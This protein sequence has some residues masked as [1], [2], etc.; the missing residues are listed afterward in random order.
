M[1]LSNRSGTI[2]S[3]DIT[4]YDTTNTSNVRI[5]PDT[6]YEAYVVPRYNGVEIAR[7]ATVSTT[8]SNAPLQLVGGFTKVVYDN[9]KIGDKQISNN[10]D[11]L[12]VNFSSNDYRRIT[13]DNGNSNFQEILDI[14]KA[15]STDDEIATDETSNAITVTKNVS[16]GDFGDTL[17]N[18]NLIINKNGASL[19]AN[20]VKKVTINDTDVDNNPISKV[21]LGNVNVGSDG[22]T[23]GANV[24]EIEV[25]VGT[26]V[27]FYVET[28]NNSNDN[29]SDNSSAEKTVK[30]NGVFITA[31][32]GTEVTATATNELTIKGSANDEVTIVSDVDKNKTIKFT[33]SQ[34]TVNV[35][36]AR[37]G[38]TLT[39]DGAIT[40]VNVGSEDNA[41]PSKGI[42]DVSNVGYS[43]LN[44]VNGGAK[45]A[46]TGSA[47]DVNVTATG[48][49]V[50]S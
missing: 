36:N 46:I 17:K 47:K 37:S 35:T 7:T 45:V 31:M 3:A 14:V 50:F 25:S 20:S 11:T 34:K 41:A 30:I 8:T 21:Y 27:K 40:T 22:V 9:K 16:G 15:L 12:L 44:L 1:K 49:A 43:D 4:M 6:Q 29:S 26:K 19:K 10:G 39:L 23:L 38:N 28:N 24:D 5:S 18:A 2:V 32:P 33:N 48:Q 42:V 13:K